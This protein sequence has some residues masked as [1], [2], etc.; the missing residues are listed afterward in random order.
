[1]D[2]KKEATLENDIRKLLSKHDD[3][4]FLVVVIPDN[5]PDDY[6]IFGNACGACAAEKVF[7]WVVTEKIIHK[8]SQ[9]EIKH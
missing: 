6:T 1:M 7:H 5:T 3:A 8:E 4:S 9:V 2:M